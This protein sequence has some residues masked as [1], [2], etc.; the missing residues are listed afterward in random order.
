LNDEFKLKSFHIEQVMVGYFKE[1][2]GLD[3]FGALFQFFVDLPE[4]INKP[5]IPDR[6]D[7]ERF[8]DEYLKDL[9]DNQRRLI[10]EARDCFLVKLEDFDT[11]SGLGALFSPCFRARSGP[12]EQFLFDLGIP[13]FLDPDYELRIEGEVQERQGSFRK[14]ILDRIGKILVDRRIRFSVRTPIPGIDLY[15]W[16]VKNDSVSPQPRGEITDHRTKN[17]PEHTKYRGDHYVECFAIKDGVCIA[18]VRQN[19]TL[20]AGR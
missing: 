17:D 2:P 1:N 4:F 6:A 7:P 9:S 8:I 15:K 12:S 20:S 18:K 16:K 13:T 3:V 19:V 11:E 5:N 14:F 10:I